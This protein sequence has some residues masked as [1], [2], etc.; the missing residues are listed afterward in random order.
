MIRLKG[1]SH[2]YGKPLLSYTNTAHNDGS[3]TVTPVDS[4]EAMKKV[5]EG[6]DALVIKNVREYLKC[7][8][9]VT[10]EARE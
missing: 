9:K 10:D 5:L 3:H 4:N 2:H 8:C 1:C 6:V 7:T